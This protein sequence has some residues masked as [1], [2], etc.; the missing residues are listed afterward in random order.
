[1]VLILKY[2]NNK[3]IPLLEKNKNY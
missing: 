3:I 1:M 2:L